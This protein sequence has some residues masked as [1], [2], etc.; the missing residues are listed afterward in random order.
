MSET[1]M[2]P[3]PISWINSITF[4]RDGCRV[5]IGGGDPEELDVDAETANRILWLLREVAA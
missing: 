4:D 3:I 5:W 1:V 2:L